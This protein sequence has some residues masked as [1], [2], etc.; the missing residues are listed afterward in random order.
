MKKKIKY[1]FSAIAG[2]FLLSL[3]SACSD[4]AA[5]TSSV[6]RNKSNSEELLNTGI[7]SR[8]LSII[9]HRCSGCGKCVRVDP[10]HFSLDNTSRK[11]EIISNKNLSSSNLSVAISI[12]RDQA[13]ELL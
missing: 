6:N 4:Q 1:I 7:D 13:I 3:L 9:E 2:L 8:Q 5:I 12:C 10:E 11:A